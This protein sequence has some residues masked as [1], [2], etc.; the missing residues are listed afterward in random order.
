MAY[1]GFRRKDLSGMYDWKKLI[2]DIKNMV[3]EILYFVREC[4]PQVQAE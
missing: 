4:Q 1:V 2:S 3:L